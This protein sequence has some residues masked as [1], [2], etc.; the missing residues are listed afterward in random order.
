LPV[1]VAVS[2]SPNSPP[3]NAAP[4]GPLLTDLSG[5]K[6]LAVDD[7]VDSVEVAKRILSARGAQV[8]TANSVA[9][10]MDVLETFTPDVI[11]S[12]IGMPRQDGY[13]FIQRLRGRPAF[14]GIPA[15]ALTAL[16]R[17]EDRTRALNAG[18]QSHIAKPLGAAELVAVVRSF[19]KLRLARNVEF[20][21]PSP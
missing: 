11:L 6:V 16:A 12:D 15:V 18:F 1:S 9:G 14:S 21:A 7:D 13:E 5:L 20:P 4:D 3:E 10:A 19:G 17:A 8:R 2:A